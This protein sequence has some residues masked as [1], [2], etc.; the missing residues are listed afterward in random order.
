MKRFRLFSVFLV[1]ISAVSFT[2]CDTE[3]VDPVL[4]DN[5]QNPEDP[6]N[7]GPGDGDAV[8]T[9]DFNGETFTA[10]STQA[11]VGNGLIVIGGFRGANGESVS[12]AIDGTSVGTYNDA[13]MSYDP[14]NSTEYAYVN[15]D[16]EEGT[17][18]SVNITSINTQNQTI[19]G[20]FSFT[21]WWS[22]D[23][24]EIDPIE[25][26]NG[27]F[28][29]IPYTGDPGT[30]PIGEDEFVATVDDLFIN[31][32]ND[33]V[34]V[35]AGE[36]EDE[37]LSLNANHSTHDIKLFLKTNT[38]EGTYDL[39]GDMFAWPRARFYDAATDIDHNID[40]GQIIITS[41]DGT[42]MVGSFSL[43]VK[44]EDGQTIH[45]VSDGGFDVNYAD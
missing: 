44:N 8:F 5:P 28:E 9:V 29:N 1:L 27:V 33:L 17:S 14:G 4:I 20:T 24:D 26:T 42:R 34:V 39:T 7:P 22:N 37:T 38:A 6:N 41:N 2:A 36:G 18:G 30:N 40:E 32:A 23:E 15:F 45:Y 12:L 31:Y 16:L 35:V 13:L 11:S 21:G 43:V 25:F 19:S 3:P 10:T